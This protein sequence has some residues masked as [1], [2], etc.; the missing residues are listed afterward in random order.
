MEDRHSD[1]VTVAKEAIKL[2][3][4]G[5][6]FFEHAAAT[7]HNELGRKMFQKLAND[8]VG[9][10]KAFGQLFASQIGSDNWKKYIAEEEKNISSVIEELK[11]RVHEHETEARASELEA[12]RIG[13]ELER[14][15]IT[16]FE[17]SAQ[18]TNDPTAQE[19]FNKICDEERIHYDLLQAQYDSVT[20]SGFWFDVAEFRMDGKY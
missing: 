19:I 16:F 2:E 20:N 18:T 13:M 7:T 3:I 12:I 14:K 10:L 15:A 8:E 17:K 1:I 9:H 6:S 5:R 4:N 11:A